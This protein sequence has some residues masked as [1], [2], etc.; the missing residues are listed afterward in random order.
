MA[1][2]QLNFRT[3][4]P[5]DKRLQLEV[6]N[7]LWELRFRSS[8]VLVEIRTA[9][10]DRSMNRLSGKIYKVPVW[11]PGARYL[12]TKLHPRTGACFKGEQSS[13]NVCRTGAAR[14]TSN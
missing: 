7:P 6:C 13:T 2:I 14:G 12:C 4:L 3:V 8:Y 5:P 1:G 11:N 9:E 10:R